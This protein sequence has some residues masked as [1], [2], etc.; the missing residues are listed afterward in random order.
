LNLGLNTGDDIVL[1]A[2]NRKRFLKKIKADGDSLVFARQ[3]H[4]GEVKYVRQSGYY[5]DVDGFVTDNKNLLLSLTVADCFP[6]FLGDR[7]TG[8]FS[9][10]HMGWRGTAAGILKNAVDI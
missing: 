10:L 7:G 5:L 8:L 1:I 6:V 9:L 4:S 2:K 3:V